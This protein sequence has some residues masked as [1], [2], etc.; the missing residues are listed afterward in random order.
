MSKVTSRLLWFCFTSFCDWPAKHAPRSQPI[1]SK[2]KTNRAFLARVFPRRLHVFASISDW[3]IAFF[4][5]VVIG[6][7]NYFGF[8]LRHSKENSSS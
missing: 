4:V 5:S 3:L 1:N 8:D 2:T 6:H 7:S